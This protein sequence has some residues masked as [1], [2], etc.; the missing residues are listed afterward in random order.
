MYHAK[1]VSNKI[2]NLGYIKK[3]TLPK[4]EAEIMTIFVISRLVLLYQSV[5]GAVKRGTSA[6]KSGIFPSCGGRPPIFASL[7]R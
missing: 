7:C 3:Y 2:N 4:K 5:A 1:V 6:V